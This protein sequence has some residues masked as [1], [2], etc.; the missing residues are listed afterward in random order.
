MAN[1][2]VGAMRLNAFV[3]AHLAP[4][5]FELY[6]DLGKHMRRYRHAGTGVMFDVCCDEG[7]YG[8]SSPRVDTTLKELRLL[9]ARI[10]RLRLERGLVDTGNG[11]Y[12]HREGTNMATMA[13]GQGTHRATSQRCIVCG[14]TK[15]LQ[16]FARTTNGGHKA[17]CIGCVN[18]RIRE[19][20]AANQAARERALV[21]AA[22]AAQPDTS[23][24]D[25]TLQAADTVDAAL[26][27]FQPEPEPEPEPAPEPAPVSA[28]AEVPGN[29]IAL[30]DFM[31]NHYDQLN[32]QPAAFVSQDF[33]FVIVRIAG[34]LYLL[35]PDA[36]PGEALT[37]RSMAYILRL[38]G[39]R[40]AAELQGALF[41]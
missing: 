8:M 10:E 18:R 27:A 30:P 26:E 25:Q 23:A 1:S 12:V 38:M 35:T 19:I 5:G 16:A 17:T 22:M 37:E 2:Q 20:K 39:E 34:K 31:A 41:Y 33:S 3:A 40:N 6:R 9:M 13:T 24:D 29:L 11:L 15:P 21:S 28:L 14:E 7:A 4:L 36:G 32:E